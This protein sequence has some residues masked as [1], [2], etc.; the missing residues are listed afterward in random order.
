MHGLPQLFH[1]SVFFIK[2][3][4]LNGL[5]STIDVNATGTFL[6]GEREGLRL[7]LHRTQAGVSL[8]FRCDLSGDELGRACGLSSG[9]I[10]SHPNHQR[11]LRT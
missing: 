9:L 4:F 10:L 8:P 2:T 6:P 5:R 1:E 11:V 3:I 7:S